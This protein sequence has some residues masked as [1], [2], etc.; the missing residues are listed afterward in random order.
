MIVC[1][2]RAAE[3]K[4]ACWLTAVYT[5]AS[6]GAYTRPTLKRAQ[7]DRMQIDDTEITPI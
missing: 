7:M 5:G 6:E 2:K 3:A 1:E 4:R